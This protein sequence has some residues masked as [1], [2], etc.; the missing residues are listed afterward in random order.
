M[1][2][3][4]APSPDPES[5]NV[6]VPADG[7]SDHGEDIL[8][9]ETHA[10]L[11][12][13]TDS[14]TDPNHR[15]DGLNN[16]RSLITILLVVHHTAIFYGGYG[17][18]QA[19][20]VDEEGWLCPMPLSLPLAAFNVL[21]QS[22]VPALFFFLAGRFSQMTLARW[23]V[24]LIARRGEMS[25]KP[26]IR[27]RLYRLFVPAIFYTLLMEP[28]LAA[29]R[30]RHDESVWSISFSHLIKFSGIRNGGNIGGGGPIIWYL[31]FLS[32]LEV[33]AATHPPAEGWGETLRRRK[34]VWVPQLWALVILASFIIRVLFPSYSSESSNEDSGVSMPRRH[35][36]PPL[37]QQLGYLPQYILAYVAGHASI[38]SGDMYILNLIPDYSN[39]PRRPLFNLGI[40]IAYASVLLILISTVSIRF[41]STSV[42]DI[43]QQTLYH[44]TS[45][46]NCTSFVYAIWNEVSFATI[47]PAIIYLFTTHLNF[48]VRIW[49]AS[50]RSI[51]DDSVGEGGTYGSGD[52][53]TPSLNR[54]RESDDSHLLARYS[55]GVI[56]FHPL[57][58]LAVGLGVNALLTSGTNTCPKT[59]PVLMTGLNGIINVLL[60]F[61]AAGAAIRFIPGVGSVI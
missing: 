28:T 57:V 40:W 13:P 36:P 9:T 39:Q 58:G 31:A 5:R 61:L 60:S 24:G 29:M 59:D 8:V 19:S 54:T 12:P 14:C 42:A 3:A 33:I 20:R 38:C 21:V 51:R 53:N 56:L 55:Y 16:L 11:L 52:G 48:P 26:F 22:F 25:P 18:P 37:K 46:F 50:R 27:K 35:P 23:N 15:D 7:E 10:L 1:S 43:D 34:R 49:S 47:A 41:S 44:M 6:P 30:G 4:R 2:G 32:L 45:G 17:S